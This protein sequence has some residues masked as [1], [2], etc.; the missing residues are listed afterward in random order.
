[1]TANR[2]AAIALVLLISIQFAWGA[3]YISRTSFVHSDQRVFTLWDDAM[4]SMQYARHLRLGNGLV[5]NAGDEPVQG[6]TNLGVT[7][8]M[9]ALHLLPLAE[10]KI[11]LSV[12]LLM[13]CML[14]AST[15]LP[16]VRATSTAAWTAPPRPPLAG[17][18]P[19]PHRSP[20][21]RRRLG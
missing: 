19:R 6:F 3:Q 5:W 14:A 7:L 20:G 8:V 21:G 13:L 2:R 4:I 18:C 11:S 16:V 15:A 9:S 1:M 17:P 12:Q 10:S